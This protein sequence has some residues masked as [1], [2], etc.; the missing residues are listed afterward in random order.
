MPSKDQVRCPSTLTL[1]FILNVAFSILSECEAAVNTQRSLAADDDLTSMLSYFQTARNSPVKTPGATEE[2][3]DSDSIKKKPKEKCRCEERL[4]RRLHRHI[5]DIS[6]TDC[7]TQGERPFWLMYQTTKTTQIWACLLLLS[8][9][10][11]G[12]N[13]P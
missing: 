11:C 3:V 10:Q 12:S 1:L 4:S 7:H 6:F 5:K 13:Y 2:K 9:L 8:V